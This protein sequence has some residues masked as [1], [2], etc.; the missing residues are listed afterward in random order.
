MTCSRSVG[1]SELAIIE[2]IRFE[3]DDLVVALVA[4]ILRVAS[5][6]AL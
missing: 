3:H 5:D 6:T 4:R 1:M 2:A